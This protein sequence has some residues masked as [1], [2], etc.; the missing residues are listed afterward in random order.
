VVGSGPDGGDSER[1][2]FLREVAG[3]VPLRDRDRA[4]GAPPVPRPP[5]EAPPALIVEEDGERVEGRAHGVTRAQLAD[6]RAGRVRCEATLDLHHDDRATALRRLR[7][8]LADGVATRRRCVLVVHGRGLHSTE[9]PV[10][11]ETVIAALAASGVVRGFCS[12]RPA[13]GGPG[14]TYVLLEEGPVR[15][16]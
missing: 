3:A 1:D 13:D 16:G 9:G 11:R 10:L 15:G 8:F 12:A 14:A 5:A 7:R 4:P 2:L 6:L